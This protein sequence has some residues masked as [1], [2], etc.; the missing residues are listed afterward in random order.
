MLVV[1]I[2]IGISLVIFIGII[3]TIV[4]A[5][6]K[7]AF[8]FHASIQL[9]ILLIFL[10]IT[11]SNIF[12]HLYGFY[13]ID[14][15]EEYLEVCLAPFITIYVYS[16]ITRNEQQ[17][18]LKKELNLKLL[19]SQR[20][21]LIKEIHHRVKNIIQ[22]IASLLH[23]EFSDIPEKSVQKKIKETSQRIQ[24]LAGAYDTLLSSD[25]ITEVDANSFLTSIIYSGFSQNRDRQNVPQPITEIENI[26]LPIEKA[27]PLGLCLYEIIS[28]AVF[29]N[30]NQG[31]PEVY[32]LQKDTSY[33][34]EISNCNVDFQGK[35]S[36]KL[37]LFI[38]EAMLD[39]LSARY[40]L[41]TDRRTLTISLPSHDTEAAGS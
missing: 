17:E 7:K 32:F 29:D 27:Y 18:L 11:V 12:E 14:Q 23:L 9:I 33:Q 35:E 2:N 5:I 24:V 28:N 22:F 36:D 40:S 1:G 3:H 21:M 13:V 4:Q 19:L 10:V 26:T 41:S 30:E 20:E 39:Q 37:S 16:I 34:L 38:F 6:R 8:L 15:A 25:N 31:T